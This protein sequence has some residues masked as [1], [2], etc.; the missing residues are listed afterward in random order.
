MLLEEEEEQRKKNQRSVFIGDPIDGK[1]TKKEV[2]EYFLKIAYTCRKYGIQIRDV[3]ASDLVYVRAFILN[4]GL[5]VSKT[6]DTIDKIVLRINESCIQRKYIGD[7]KYSS[8]RDLFSISYEDYGD[9]EKELAMR[10][11]FNNKIKTEIGNSCGLKIEFCSGFILEVIE[12]SQENGEEEEN[13]YI[14]DLGMN[15]DSS[16]S[17]S[18]Q[19]S[20]D[21]WSPRFGEFSNG[22]IK[23]NTNP[24][25]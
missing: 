9:S 8:V 4:N 11:H 7:S 10:T 20:L 19:I 5:F 21:I 18:S 23:I 6:Y 16:S 24:L 17:S 25:Y 12:G 14:S 13:Y 2:I 3:L 1:F 22:V 15:F